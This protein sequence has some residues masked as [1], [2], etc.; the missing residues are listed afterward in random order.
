MRQKLNSKPSSMLK[1]KSPK[2]RENKQ[3]GVNAINAFHDQFTNLAS[4]LR[5]RDEWLAPHCH[6]EPFSTGIIEHSAKMRTDF[7]IGVS[8]YG[9][10]ANHRLRFR[11]RSHNMRDEYSRT[12]QFRI[13]TLGKG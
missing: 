9:W 12:D 11:N 10:F 6:I 5:I 3:R 7:T 1:G 13:A 4:K 8:L 2:K